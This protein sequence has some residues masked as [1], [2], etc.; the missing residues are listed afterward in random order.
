MLLAVKNLWRVCAKSNDPARISKKNESIKEQKLSFVSE[1]IFSLHINKN[2]LEKDIKHPSL[3]PIDNN[4]KFYPQYA[5]SFHLALLNV[6]ISIKQ[7][8]LQIKNFTKFSTTE[9]FF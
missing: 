7:N 3:E 8:I 2:I 6:P 5:L 1:N 4:E 9:F